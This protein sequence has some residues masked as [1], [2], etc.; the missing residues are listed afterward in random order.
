MRPRDGTVGFQIARMAT[1]AHGVVTRAELLRAGISSK[2]IKRRLRTGALLGEHPGVYRVG[3]RAPSIEATYLAAGG[4]AAREPFSPAAR[5]AIS[6][7][8]SRAHRPGRR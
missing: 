4:R 7:V 1:A 8:P 6:S 3:H 2:E 5:R